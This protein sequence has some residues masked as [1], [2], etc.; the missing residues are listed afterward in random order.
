MDLPAA[1]ASAANI[2]RPCVRSPL[3]PLPCSTAPPSQ[4][5]AHLDIK[6][7]N[8]CRDDA[9]GRV[10]LIDGALMHFKDSLRPVAKADKPAVNALLKPPGPCG[11][12]A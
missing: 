3:S 10:T 5:I 6:P 12:L 9:T 1:S 8:I 4:G 11:T 7:D 2:P